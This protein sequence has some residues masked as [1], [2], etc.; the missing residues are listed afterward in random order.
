MRKLASTV[1]WLVGLILVILPYF[2]GKNLSQKIVQLQVLT[3]PYLWS[4]GAITCIC[5]ICG[6]LFVLALWPISEDMA[7][8]AEKRLNKSKKFENKTT[9]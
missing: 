3:W 1:V 9:K 7:N 6:V 2:I 4:L 5:F 8:Y